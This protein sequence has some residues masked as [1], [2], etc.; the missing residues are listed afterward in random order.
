MSSGQ[1]TIDSF[2]SSVAGAV[3]T[4]ST[5]GPPTR[6][7]L[8]DNTTDFVEGTGSLEINAAIG[9]F[10]PWGSFA[11][12]IY[13]AADE[14]GPQDW[15]VSDSLSIWIKVHTAPTHPEYMVFRI[16]L[17]DR[18]TIGG[19]I[20]EYLYENATILDAETDW[21]ELKVPLAEIESDGTV[22]P[23]DQ[24]FVRAPDNWGGFTY[25]NRVLDRDRI[26]GYNISLVTTGWTD[27]ENI[28]AD[29]MV[30]SFDS[31]TRFGTR[32]V[33]FI[34]FN[35]KTLASNLS[36]W[37]W[38]QSTISIEEG[39][40]ATPGTNA[41]KWVQGDEWGGG[42]TGIGFTIAPAY[43]MA[44]V[45][46]TDSV[47]FKLKADAGTGPMRIQFEDGAAKRGT[48]FTPVADGAW[49]Y[50]AFKLSKTV[51]QDGTANFDSSNVTVL[52]LMAEASGIP[53]KTVYIDD[54][55]TGNPIIDVAPPPPPSDVSAVGD[56]YYNLVIWQDAPGES[57]ETYTVYAS[58]KPITDLADP[59]V[60]VIRVAVPEQ[61]QTTVHWLTY[62][63]VDTDVTNYYA[64]TCTDEAGNVS[65]TFGASAG[66]VTN[67]AK[68][69]P[70]ISLNPPA[71]F[72]ADGDLSEWE[73]SGIK[74]FVFKKSVSHI[75]TGSFDNDD[76]LTANI[77]F[78]IDNNYLYLAADVIDNV[79]SFDPAGNWYEDDALEFY[80]G[81]YDGRSGAKHSS[82]KRGEQPDYKINIS[83][84]FLVNEYNGNRNI[85]VPD[86][87]DYYFEGL[88]ASDWVMET[89]IKLTDITFGD[90]KPFKPV[91]G[92]RVPFDIVVHDSDT[93]NVRDGNLTLSPINNDNSW[94]TP[95]NW[96]YTW[97]GNQESPTAVADKG[98]DGVP[99]SYNL[100]QNYPN[101]FNPTTRI[102]Y[103]IRKPGLV[104]IELYNTLG[105]K[106]RTLVDEVKPAGAY[107]LEVPANN[108]PSGV[109]FYRI[110]AGDFKQTKKMLLMK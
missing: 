7:N 65:L 33:P 53:G 110:N 105:Q 73:N 88:G 63:L 92:M 74:P 91:N 97:I 48:V 90:D 100:S 29:S 82:A 51:Y 44:G 45:W 26:V 106:V 55:W 32:A 109:Y 84:A 77:Y 80:I 62:P 69:M 78:A 64:V 104:R 87:A 34:F 12:L 70:T 17:A 61:E 67:T 30:V 37:S 99:L 16:H 1:V 24:G 18:P 9:A 58:S 10:H 94:Q 103:A 21:V 52:G 76:D 4:L 47:K 41:I 72:K 20:E 27:P 96:T 22:V 19:V 2:D 42:W 8:T 83:H 23:N 95:R 107:T 68:G 60:E 101:P 102:S 79:Y 81:L 38:G 14:V 66:P 40:G 6:M 31:F 46:A 35:G 15:S 108:L 50:Y 86:S 93:K 75:G 49:H 98:T 71:Q 57:K 59:A 25:N 39:A 5:E 85:Y 13:R 36:S 54:W 43:N 56:Q 28:P 11:Q 3:Y 89:R